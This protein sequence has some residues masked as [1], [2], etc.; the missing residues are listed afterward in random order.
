MKPVEPEKPKE[1]KEKEK[2]EKLLA[3]ETRK[4]QEPT[5]RPTEDEPLVALKRTIA[6]T[7]TSTLEKLKIQATSTMSTSNK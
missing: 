4:P 7:L 5:P 1:D 6:P 2:I 3:L